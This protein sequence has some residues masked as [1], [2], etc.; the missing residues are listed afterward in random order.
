M[1]LVGHVTKATTAAHSIVV[2]STTSMKSRRRSSRQARRHT[3]QRFSKLAVVG[4]KSQP[5]LLRQMIFL[6]AKS[7]TMQRRDLRTKAA[8]HK[9]FSPEF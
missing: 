7:S 9:A 8:P 6:M 2:A 5:R 3:R 1:G 4:A